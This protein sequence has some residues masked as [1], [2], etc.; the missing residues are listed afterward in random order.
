MKNTPTSAELKQLWEAS[1]LALEAF[2]NT[3]GKVYQQLELKDK[4]D[5][6]STAEQLDILAS[7]GKLIKRPITSDGHKVSLG[8]KQDQFAQM[9]GK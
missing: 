9:W 6:M 7:D 5:Q 1:G 2:F 3:R 8:F 4:L